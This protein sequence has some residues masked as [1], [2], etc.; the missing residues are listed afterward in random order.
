MTRLRSIPA[1][2]KTNWGGMGSKDEGRRMKDESEIRDLKSQIPNSSF[3]L[4]FR[5]LRLWGGSASGAAAGRGGA[6]FFAV[7]A[8]QDLLAH[9]LGGGLDFLHFFAD[10][11]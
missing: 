8:F 11:G 1:M 3:I 4:S 9:V 6:A 7:A 2:S 10:A 5:G